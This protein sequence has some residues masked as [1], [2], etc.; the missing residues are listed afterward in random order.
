MDKYC[1]MVLEMRQEINCLNEIIE[2]Q[3]NIIHAK[4]NIIW[5]KDATIERMRGILDEYQD[6]WEKTHCI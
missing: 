4:D 1:K 2:K 6:E 3:E 5:C